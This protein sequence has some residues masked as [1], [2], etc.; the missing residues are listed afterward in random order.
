MHVCLYK[1]V[2]KALTQPFYMLHQLTPTFPFLKPKC[3]PIHFLKGHVTINTHWDC[4][5]LGELS[6]LFGSQ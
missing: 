4:N 6:L 2:P 5:V 1:M 3:L